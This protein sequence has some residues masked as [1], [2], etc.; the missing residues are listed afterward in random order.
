MRVGD[1]DVF[2][3]WNDVQALFV[4]DR[5]AR[6][7]LFKSCRCRKIGWL[8]SCKASTAATQALSACGRFFGAVYITLFCSWPALFLIGRLTWIYTLLILRSEV[9][10]MNVWHRERA[11]AIS[12]KAWV[13]L[14]YSLLVPSDELAPD[15]I[16]LVLFCAFVDS[17]TLVS[18][19][20]FKSL[21]I[22]GLPSNV[23]FSNV[24]L[25]AWTFLVII[26]REIS[27][28]TSI[29]H[30]VVTQSWYRNPARLK[31]PQLLRYKKKDRT[32]LLD[33]RRIIRLSLVMSIIIV[34]SLQLLIF[35][36]LHSLYEVD[37]ILDLR[38]LL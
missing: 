7:L 23:A 9:E 14:V 36:F 15:M 13:R 29:E 10:R 31:A 2:V 11:T 25:I 22:W 33:L 21:V 1:L 18:N 32:C 5:A 17:F 24:Y 27:L 35:T 8:L 4:G 34:I 6:L 12:W 20:Q 19:S 28:G 26:G 3:V 38:A 16:S 37:R 30:Q